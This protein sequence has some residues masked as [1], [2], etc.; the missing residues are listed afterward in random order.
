MALKFGKIQFYLHNCGSL[1]HNFPV[2]AGLNQCCYV[3]LWALRNGFFPYG[4]CESTKLSISHAHNIERQ[5]FFLFASPW[6]GL[7]ELSRNK[8]CCDPLLSHNVIY[9]YTQSSR[10]FTGRSENFGTRVEKLLRF[11]LS[12]RNSF[13]YNFDLWIIFESANLL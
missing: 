6:K 2:K 13:V 1:P 3:I 4:F 5:F 12:S 7:K 10:L 11:P 9:I 8:S